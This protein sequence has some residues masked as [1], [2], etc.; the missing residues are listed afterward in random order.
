MLGD[1]YESK[2]NK[3]YERAALYFERCFQWNPQTQLD[4]VSAPPTFTTGSSW[5]ARAP[6]ELYREITTHE[7][8]P[9][10]F[11]KPANAWPT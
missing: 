7:T 3:M 8:D 5:N 10:A 11:R 6:I 9:S 1:I 2:A 4:A